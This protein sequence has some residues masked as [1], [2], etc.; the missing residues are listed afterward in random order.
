MHYRLS[1]P[2][3]YRISCYT[4]SYVMKILAATE[5]LGICDFVNFVLFILYDCLNRICDLINFICVLSLFIYDRLNFIHDY[6]NFIHDRLNYIYVVS[7][8]IYVYSNNRYVFINFMYV[9]LLFIYDCLRKRYDYLIT[10]VFFGF[11]HVFVLKTYLRQT[12]AFTFYG[13]R[14]NTTTLRR[15]GNLLHNLKNEF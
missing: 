2:L 5:K 13:D 7:L 10:D 9:I 12:F 1:Y 8:F 3:R 14:R 6:S 15:A 4:Q 11:S